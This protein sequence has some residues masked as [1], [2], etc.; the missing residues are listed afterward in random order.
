MI[1]IIQVIF[2]HFVA[3]IVAVALYAIMCKRFVE[4]LLADRHYCI[5]LY[6]EHHVHVHLL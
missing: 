1:Y 2:M 6:D 5:C 3:F 4:I